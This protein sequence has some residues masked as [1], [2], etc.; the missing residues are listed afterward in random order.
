[1]PTVYFHRLL[2]V[3]GCTSQVL[4]NEYLTNR[5][6][7]KPCYQVDLTVRMQH[8]HS[9]SL[10][11]DSHRFVVKYGFPICLCAFFLNAN[12]IAMCALLSVDVLDRLW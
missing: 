4:A 10:V 8:V 2:T 11:N 1:M 7:L 5:E 6:Y 12:F 9:D 3:C